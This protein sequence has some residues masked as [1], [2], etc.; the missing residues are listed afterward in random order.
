MNKK[1]KEK[2]DKK[3]VKRVESP[4]ERFFIAFFSLCFIIFNNLKR[5][6]SFKKKKRH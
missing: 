2:K 6:L 1:R 3:D 5:L 4:D